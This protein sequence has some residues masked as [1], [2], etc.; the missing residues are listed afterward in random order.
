MSS[1][2]LCGPLH[3][4]V[5]T[6]HRHIIKNKKLIIFKKRDE[7]E[8]WGFSHLCQLVIR[9]T[10]L[11]SFT[12]TTAGSVPLH[13]KPRRG[14]TDS[15]L[16]QRP[17]SQQPAQ[18]RPP[19]RPFST[20]QTLGQEF[21]QCQRLLL[22]H[23]PISDSQQPVTSANACRQSEHC[24]KNPLRCLVNTD[25]VIF[26]SRDSSSLP[27]KT[28]LL[29]SKP[30]SSQRSRESSLEGWCCCSGEGEGRE[31]RCADERGQT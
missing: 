10:F 25:A 30:F 12:T 11:E 28:I 18:H 27:H 5:H 21:L 4:H 20:L 19:P 29:S 13:S 16:S 24:I 26:P 15:P 3:S 7:P 14:M 17:L 2:G 9:M 23:L 22:W 1:P 8:P 6:P 31:G